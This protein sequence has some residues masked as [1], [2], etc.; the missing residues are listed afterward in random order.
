MNTVIELYNING[1]YIDIYISIY[2]C[3]N[4]DILTKNI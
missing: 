1:R 2:L 3:F 4:I